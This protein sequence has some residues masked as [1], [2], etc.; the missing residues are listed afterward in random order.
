M[1]GV[2]YEECCVSAVGSLGCDIVFWPAKVSPFAS[3]AQMWCVKLVLMAGSTE[4]LLG[5]V[6]MLLRRYIALSKEPENSRALLI[7]RQVY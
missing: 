1:D 2:S 7:D 3:A 4:M 6:Q 5:I